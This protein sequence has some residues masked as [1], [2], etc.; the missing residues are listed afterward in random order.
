MPL[1]RVTPP[2]VTHLVPREVAEKLA[3]TNPSRR[4][5]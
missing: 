2:A 3:E 5:T 4:C 1:V